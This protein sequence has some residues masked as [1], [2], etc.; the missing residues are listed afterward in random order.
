MNK[1]LFGLLAATFL[2]FGCNKF[3]ELDGV[4]YEIDGAEFAIPLGSAQFSMSDLLDNVEENT[5]LFFDPDG[6]IRLNYKGRLETKTSIEI[7]ESFQKRLEEIPFVPIIDT[8]IAL[9]FSIDSIDVDFMDLRRGQVVLSM[10]NT[11]SANLK[12]DWKFPSVHQGTDTLSGSFVIGQFGSINDTFDL[13]GYRLAPN[14]DS[15]YFE[16]TATNLSTGEKV[17]IPPGIFNMYISNIEFSLFVGYFGRVVHESSPDTIL[18]DFFDSWTTGDIYFNEPKISIYSN[19]SFGVPT[20]AIIHY[21]DVNTINEGVISLQ[22]PYIDTPPYFGYPS[23][24]NEIGQ[25]VIDTFI[26]DNQ[27]SNMPQILGAGP[28]EIVY[29]VEA[30]T[31]PDEDENIRGFITENSEYLFIVEV[32]LPLYGRAS[33]FTINDTLECDF[34]GYDDVKEAEFKIVSENELGVEVRLQGYFIDENGV[35]L[36]SLFDEVKPVLEPAPVDGNG[37]VTGVGKSVLFSDFTADEF[38]RLKTAKRIL[39][40]TQFYTSDNGQK[41]VRVKKDQKMDIR[42]GLKFGT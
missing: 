22:S 37:E 40:E 31:N 10:F 38:S 6:T 11:Q 17:V 7:F 16:Y 41:S 19:N 2:T 27:N 20:Q 39:L 29:F 5:F 13:E 15:I 12:V 36:D 25:T 34:S 18:I 23:F 4:N 24:P 28:K 3:D 32:D 9:P 8:L 42:M 33:G 14:R 35:V 26:F 30:I 1:L 21:F